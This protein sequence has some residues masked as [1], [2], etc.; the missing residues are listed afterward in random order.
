MGSVL[1]TPLLAPLAGYSPVKALLWLIRLY[2]R[3][4]AFVCGVQVRPSGARI[5]PRPPVAL[6][7][8]APR[9]VA[10][11]GLPIRQTGYFTCCGALSCTTCA[12]D[13]APLLLRLRSCRL[14]P[15]A[16]ASRGTVPHR[17]AP[18]VAPCMWCLSLAR[19]RTR[20]LP[21]ARGRAAP[22]PAAGHRGVA[23][24]CA[25]P[26]GPLQRQGKKNHG[27]GAKDGR[28]A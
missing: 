3:G 14:L 9:L 16:G 27:A 19:D 22:H 4:L 21:P 5:P 18:S 20:T 24:L 23:T 15:P 8:P 12:V 11:V 10:A 13:H 28:R 7:R 2:F 17:P 6:S 25:Q 1:S 26:A